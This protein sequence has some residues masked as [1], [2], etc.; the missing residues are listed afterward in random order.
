MSLPTPYFDQSTESTLVEQPTLKKLDDAALEAYYRNDPEKYCPGSMENKKAGQDA[1]DDAFETD[2][3]YGWFVVLAAF[4][5][6]LIGL[7]IVTGWGVMQDYYEQHN[8]GVNPNVALQLSLVGATANCMM[9]LMSVFSQILISLVGV[10]G[11]ILVAAILCTAGL[12]LASL[13]TEMWHL[14]LTQGVIYGI[15]CSIIFYVGMST[16]A[17]WFDKRSGL[18]LGLASSGSCIG[19]LVMPFLITP[20]NRTLGAAWCY[21]ILGIIALFICIIACILF[22]DKRPREKNTRIRDVVDLS[23]CKNIDLIIWVVADTLI[24]AGYYVPLFFLPSYSTYLGLS[25]SQGSLLI[26]IAS[27][28]NAVGRI[29]T[30]HIADKIGYMNTTI[31]CSTLAGLSS[32][33]IWTIAYDF[34]M[35]MGFACVF[36]LTGGVFVTLGPSITRIVTGSEKFDTGYAM[37]LL[38]TVLAMYGPNLAAYIE[39][40]AGASA[41]FSYKVFTAV[42]YISGTLVLL[43]LKLK[44]SPNNGFFSRFLA[45]L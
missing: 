14:L 29:V 35:L 4:L 16:V 34:N 5:V 11:G 37:F 42:M 36:G 40:S 26:S 38:L 43:Y 21:R 41:F 1:D 7:G 10:K 6:Q 31:I 19:G 3:G 22:K 33:I 9:N 24:E 15:G 28:C 23:V 12:E 45:R 25:D 2:G 39:S 27:A 44:L 17:L 8:F 13:S 18:A 32:I 30:G 20:L